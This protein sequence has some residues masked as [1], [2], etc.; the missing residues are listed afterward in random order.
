MSLKFVVIFVVSISFLFTTDM[1]E[2]MF[3]VD[4]Y[5]EL[6]LIKEIAGAESAVRVHECDISELINIA[7]L[8][9]PA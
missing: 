1:A 3:Q 8:Q 6:I 5:S 9:M 4:V 7:L 2:H